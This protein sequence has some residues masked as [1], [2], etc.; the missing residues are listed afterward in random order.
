MQKF[1]FSSEECFTNEPGP[2]FWYISSTVIYCREWHLEPGT[3][4]MEVCVLSWYSCNRSDLLTLS[5]RGLG[6]ACVA[7]RPEGMSAIR[8]RCMSLAGN[9]NSTLWSDVYWDLTENQW[10]CRAM[11]SHN[12]NQ[13]CVIPTWLLRCNLSH[14]TFQTCFP[15]L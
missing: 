11:P 14:L 3:S 13:P 8:C 12:L 9:E 6:L 1:S 2:N 15:H 10:P 7:L 5:L 4:V